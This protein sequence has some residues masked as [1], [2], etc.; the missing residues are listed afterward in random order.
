[1]VPVRRMDSKRVSN[2]ALFRSVNQRIRDLNE[3]FSEQ[4]DL[5]TSFFCECPDLGCMEC[6]SVPVEAYR[7][8]RE[9]PTWFVVSPGHVDAELEEVAEDHGSYMVVS[10]PEH[11]LPDAASDVT[12][13]T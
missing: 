10:V 9:V 7:R 6:V 3:A 8:I 11:L 5:E 2:L 13:D 12:S 1:V 4:L